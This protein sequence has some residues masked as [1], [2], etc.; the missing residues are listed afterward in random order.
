MNEI[1]DMSA[2]KVTLNLDAMIKVAARAVYHAKSQMERYQGEVDGAHYP[3][4]P[5]DD[6]HA[7]HTAQFYADLVA[8]TAREYADAWAVYFALVECKTREDVTIVR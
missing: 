6:Y 5:E 3:G 4:S 7:N 2:G 1:Y 8:K